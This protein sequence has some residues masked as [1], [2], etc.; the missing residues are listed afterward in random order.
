MIMHLKHRTGKVMQVRTLSGYVLP[1]LPTNA[2]ADVVTPVPAA[3]QRSETPNPVAYPRKVESSEELVL[4][5]E[6][7]RY[8]YTKINQDGS[9]T[10]QA[11]QTYFDIQTQDEQERS[12]A[13]L[14]VDIHA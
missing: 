1:R 11:L 14:G 7:Q 2:S 12:Q 10:S 8:S 4:A 3:D 13:L 9:K 6:K 5:R